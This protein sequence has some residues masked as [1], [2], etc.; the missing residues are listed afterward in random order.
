ML[1]TQQIKV[2]DNNQ[3]TARKAQT[4]EKYS[5]TSPSMTNKD[6]ID[7]LNFSRVVSN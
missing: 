5:Q 4:S 7:S 1:I 2:V 3:K 6:V